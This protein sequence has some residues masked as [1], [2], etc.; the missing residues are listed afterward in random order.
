[1]TKLTRIIKEITLSNKLQLG[2]YWS[3]VDARIKLEK[4]IRQSQVEYNKH[5]KYL[6][7]IIEK[8]KRNEDGKLITKLDVFEYSKKHQKV[9][10][11]S[12]ETLGQLQDLER[13]LLGVLNARNINFIKSDEMEEL[14]VIVK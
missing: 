10:T 8:R 13:M 3:V 6:D 7:R 11:I 14:E 4:S 12:M 1:M 2:S 5:I 9:F